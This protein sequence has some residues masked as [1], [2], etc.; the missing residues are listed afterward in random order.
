M[1][2]RAGWPYGAIYIS[3]ISFLPFRRN[4]KEGMPASE[5]ALIIRVVVNAGLNG[6]L[7]TRTRRRRLAGAVDPICTLN[8]MILITRCRT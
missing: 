6:C 1:R 2:V 7:V 8:K 4:N 3:K 5:C